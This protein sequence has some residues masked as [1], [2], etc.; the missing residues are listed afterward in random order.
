MDSNKTLL[1]ILGILCLFL[2]LPN[3]DKMAGILLV[4]IVVIGYGI[5]KDS[6]ITL[7][8]AAIST[9][10]ILFLLKSGKSPLV[11][12][13]IET[14]K[15][16][17]KKKKRSKKKKKKHKREGFGF[18]SGEHEKFDGDDDGD[19][20]DSKEHMFDSKQ[21]F[22]DNY[23]AMTPSQVKGLNIDTQELIKTQKSLINTLKNMGPTLTQGKEVLDTFKN[24]FGKDT[25]LNMED[26][27]NL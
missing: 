13:N 10:I 1:L 24:Y 2:V 23:K 21:T 9:Y 19:D 18:D 15:S 12:V 11:K 25:D 27:K 14:F 22:A 5:T 4:A 26:F 6:I 16:K 7:S 17:K 3:L 20:S 8:I